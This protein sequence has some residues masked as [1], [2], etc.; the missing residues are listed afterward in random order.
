MDEFTLTKLFIMLD[1]V[2]FAFKMRRFHWVT[3]FIIHTDMKLSPQKSIIQKLY[4]INNAIMVELNALPIFQRWG[5]TFWVACN[6]LGGEEV[7]L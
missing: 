7:D 2:N 4:S 1:H 3:S 5:L 6:F